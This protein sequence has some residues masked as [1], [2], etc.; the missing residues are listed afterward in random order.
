M[1]TKLY[2]LVLTVIVAILLIIAVRYKIKSDKKI[3]PLL[4]ASPKRKNKK[5]FW[6]SSPA[7]ALYA[8]LGG[9]VVLFAIPEDWV[10][11]ETETSMAL[12][13]LIWGFVNAICCFFIVRQN[14]KSIWYVLLIINVFLTYA[15]IT[16]SDFL[17]NIILISLCC[18]WFLSIIAS[19]IGARMGRRKAISENP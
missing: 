15:A 7:L 1:E 19:I 10:N 6:E 5:I 13:F 9:F 4:I 18:A 17:G 2:A 14:P 8:L 12:V 11:V 3:K 16:E